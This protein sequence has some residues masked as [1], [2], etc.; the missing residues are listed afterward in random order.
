MENI[1]QSKQRARGVSAATYAAKTAVFSALSFILY[2]LKFPL[3]FLFPSWLELHFSDFGAVIA[4]FAVGPLAGC[5]VAVL[6]VLLKLLIMGTNTGFVGEFGDVII[7]LSFVLPASLIY[8][9][10]R[11]RKGAVIALIC[12]GLCSVA[13]A[14]VS[15]RFLLIPFYGNLMGMETLVGA[16][17][18]LFPDITAGTFYSYYLWVSVVPFNAVRVAVIGIVT[19]LIYKHISRL[20]NKF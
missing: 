18:G 9:F 16:M 13:G 4:G 11:T 10:N 8:K 5:A 12:G 2:L 7:G 3:P 6:R 14:V 1:T 20:L 15:N 19:F 17:K